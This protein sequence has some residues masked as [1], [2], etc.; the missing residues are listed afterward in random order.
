[1]VLCPRCSYQ[2]LERTKRV[3]PGFTLRQRRCI[4]GRGRL[5][6]H[7]ELLHPGAPSR[8]TSSTALN[9][10]SGE[11][12]DGLT[13]DLL[14]WQEDVSSPQPG[15]AGSCSP[16]TSSL[17]GAATETGAWGPSC[18][19][20]DCSNAQHA[21]PAA[22]NNIL[23]AP[24]AC[25]TAGKQAAQEAELSHQP[26]LL[27]SAA[28]PHQPPHASHAAIAPQPHFS[29]NSLT[30]L[31]RQQQQQQQYQQQQQ[32][33]QPQQPQQQH[34]IAPAA[35]SHHIRQMSWQLPGPQQP[36]TSHAADSSQPS[37]AGA[38]PGPGSS[39]QGG[40]GQQGPGV[41]PGTVPAPPPAAAAPPSGP[42]TSAASSSQEG[43]TSPSMPALTPRRVLTKPA[44]GVKNDGYDNENSDLVLAVGDCLLNHNPGSGVSRS[45]CVQDMLG[46]G[47]FG[48][49]ASC[50]SD[51]LGRSVAVKVI[52]NQ[53]AYYHQ[54]RVEIGLLQFLNARCDP[55]DRHH[56]VRM[57]DFFLHRKHLCLV[58]EK[59]DVNLFELLK[60]NAFRGLSLSLVQMFLRQLLDALAVLREACII[61][62]DLKPENILLV[63]P[64]SGDI[65]LIDYGS[66]CFEARTVYS[67]IQS[68]FYRSPEVVLGCAYSSAIDMWSLGCVAA[69]LFLGLPLFPGASEHDLLVRIM[70]TLRPLPAWLLAEAKHTDKYF[71]RTAAPSPGVP[72]PLG[73]SL[74][75]SELAG[76]GWGRLA[77]S[78][79]RVPGQLQEGREGSGWQLRSAAEFEQ[80]SGCKATAGKRYFQ[81]TRLADII[82]AYPLRSNLTDEEVGRER[83]ARE[84]FIDWL[85]GV[86]DPD[87]LTRWS[88]RQAAAHP[89]ITGAPF[90]GPFQ[91][92][93]D[94]RPATA[95]PRQ[96]SLPAPSATASQP[97]IPIH[98]Q[99]SLG[100]DTAAGGARGAVAGRGPGQG[101]ARGGA[102]GGE[103]S[104]GR[105]QGLGSSLS[106]SYSTSFIMGATPAKRLATH[107]QGPPWPMDQ[108]LAG[109][110]QPL[111]PLQ[112]QL[113]QQPLPASSITQNLTPPAQQAA[114]GMAG[115]HTQ[116][117][118][119]H[120]YH[121]AWLPLLQSGHARQQPG[122]AAAAAGHDDDAASLRRRGPAGI[123]PGAGGA[124]RRQAGGTHSSHGHG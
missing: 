111:Q 97:P 106:A 10:G 68:R 118:G 22:A 122:P 43:V 57:L 48:Q 108:Q 11:D 85:L 93:A 109:P 78:L 21:P 52:K 45:Y 117:A 14:F 8:T 123:R 13:E 49:V 1:M 23:P 32:Q 92:P 33:Q 59:L 73:S 64:A 16:R 5:V 31:Q 79:P 89:F 25:S 63:N 103:V 50:W 113:Q 77:S 99:T 18:M 84:A 71:R 119:S 42:R 114:Q 110:S 62:C 19:H 70:E 17:A 3:A 46:Q 20:I 34:I 15:P 58:F 37:L 102:A 47:T 124:G 24:A 53:P 72:D 115:P 55:L 51:V 98:P 76:R 4:R 29:L 6:T 101:A 83:V 2:L 60:R 66:A 40:R 28:H 54:A 35:V 121:P 30:H 116:P 87:P 36:T 120:L 9:T 7:S 90:S 41:G 56:I 88:P 75:A 94:P 95:T 26:G 81:H 100:E 44:A 104:P 96:T 91:P 112:L 39:S 69:E 67:Y 105:V 74:Q 27:G 86:L 82:A 12:V 65:K 61:H 38:Q 80:R 107:T